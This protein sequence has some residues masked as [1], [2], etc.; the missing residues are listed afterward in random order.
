[1]TIPAD[2]RELLSG[3]NY[4]H[5]ATLMPDGAPHSV[6]M[7]GGLDGDRVVIFTGSTESRKARNLAGDGRLAISVTDHANP[8]RTGQL[9]GHVVETRHGE[10]ALAGMDALARKYTGEPFPWRTDDGTL[11]LIEVDWARFSELPFTH[12]PA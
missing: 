9:R 11:Y 4:V 1:M 10:E 5:V 6:A 8:Y 12:A 2:L 3:A 7:W